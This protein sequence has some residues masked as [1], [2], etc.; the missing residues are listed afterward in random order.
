MQAGKV[1]GKHDVFVEMPPV[2]EGFALPTRDELLA[3]TLGEHVKL[4]LA[5]VGRGMPERIWVIL[6]EK[7]SEEEWVGVLDNDPLS[8]PVKRGDQVAFH[9]LAAVATMTRAEGELLWQ[10]AKREAEHG[11]KRRGN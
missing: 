4:I 8:L 9:P 7:R 10:M 1:K 5:S 2:A 6:K 11:P 3:L